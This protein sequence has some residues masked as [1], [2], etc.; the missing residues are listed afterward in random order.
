MTIFYTNQ[1]SHLDPSYVFGSGKLLQ[2]LSYLEPQQHE[3]YLTNMNAKLLRSSGKNI[4]K[5]SQSWRVSS[6]SSANSSTG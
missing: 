3:M 5:I 4:L 6:P 1:W 2:I